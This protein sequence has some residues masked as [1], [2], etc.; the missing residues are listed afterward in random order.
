MVCVSVIFNTYMDD[1]VRDL[2]VSV[3]GRKV[4]LLG[5]ARNNLKLNQLLFETWEYKGE[6]LATHF[7]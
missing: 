2:D 1:V 7:H 5:Q 6:S 4:E 3:R